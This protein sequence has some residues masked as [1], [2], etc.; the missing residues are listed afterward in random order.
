[1]NEN[2]ILTQSKAAYAQWKDQWRRHAELHSHHPDIKRSLLELETSGVGRAIVCV[3]NGYSLEENIET[4]RLNQHKVDIICCDKVLGHL[5]DNGIFPKYCL[6]CDANVNFDKYLAKWKDKL[7]KIILLANVCGN[8]EWTRPEWKKVY[9]FVNEDI[10]DSQIEFGKISG[11]TNAIPAGTN[12][13]NA[14]VIMLTQSNQT[15]RRNFFGYDKMILLGFDYSWKAGGKYYAFDED[16]GG[17]D[18]YMCHHYLVS[19]T[20]NFIY[21]SGNLNFSAQWLD[22]YVRSFVLPIVQCAKDSILQFG[23]TSDLATQMDYRYKEEDGKT[24]KAQVAELRWLVKRKKEI[25]EALQS[26]AKDHWWA[27]L[28]TV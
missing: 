21:T 25:E 20:G 18:Q 24:I 4:L 23:K 2:Q 12:V 16:G 15:G 17:K 7:K 19:P 8:P 14:L 13:S 27:H 5:L 22:K 10:I 26:T 1:M 28:S 6:M 9:F 11:C 3:A